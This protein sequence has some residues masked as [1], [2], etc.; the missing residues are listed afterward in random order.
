MFTPPKLSSIPPSFKFLK[1][2][3]QTRKMGEEE[4]GGKQTTG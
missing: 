1:I 2:T 3:L 4:V